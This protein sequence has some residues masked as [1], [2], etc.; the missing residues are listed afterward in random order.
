MIGRSA[1]Q[2]ST[3]TGWPRASISRRLFDD[4]QVRRAPGGGYDPLHL[5]PQLA[6]VR[7]AV[8]HYR[9]PVA[10]LHAGDIGIRIER[11]LR[12]E[13]PCGIRIDFGIGQRPDQAALA[14]QCTF[15]PAE[16]WLNQADTRRR[17]PRPRRAIVLSNTSSLTTT[18]CA[19]QE[20]RTAGE[21]VAITAKADLD[22][23]A[24][25]QA[26]RRARP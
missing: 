21:V 19:R 1:L 24:D 26:V 23:V 7:V 22:I 9:S 13:G 2:V 8:A 5:D 10:A 4:L 20:A 11:K 15:T 12:A 25:Q 14:E 17:T 16:T 18:G 6:S 3:N